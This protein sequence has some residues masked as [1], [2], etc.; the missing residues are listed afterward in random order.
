MA[1]R[2]G[3][4]WVFLGPYTVWAGDTSPGQLEVLDEKVAGRHYRCQGAHPM[5]SLDNII[6]EHH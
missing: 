6:A 3:G 4:L 2:S 5:I 1:R